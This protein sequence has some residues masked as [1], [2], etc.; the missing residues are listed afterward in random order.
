M[1][2]L[3]QIERQITERFMVNRQDTTHEIDIVCNL[4]YNIC[5]VVQLAALPEGRLFLLSLLEG[6]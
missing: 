4:K 1:F 3:G 2:Y 6:K 5:G